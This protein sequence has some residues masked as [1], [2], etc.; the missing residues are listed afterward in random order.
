MPAYDYRCGKCRKY[1]TVRLTITEHDKKKP[2]CP[3][4]G[5]RKVTQQMASFFAV[6][7]KKS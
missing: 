7:S 1:F 6:T 4:C 5:T 3:K 2:G